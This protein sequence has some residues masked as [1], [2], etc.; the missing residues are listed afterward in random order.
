[1]KRLLSSIVLI[2][3]LLAGMIQPIFAAQE[4]TACEITVTETEAAEELTSEVQETAEAEI[5]QENPAGQTEDTDEAAEQTADVRTVQTYTT[6]KEGIAFIDEM[7]GGSC[8]GTNQL[9]S[10]EKTVNNFI[11]S[12]QLGLRQQQFDALVDLVMAY[13]SYIL[14]S[15]YKV[16]TLIASGNYTDRQ[17]AEA[18]CAWVKEGSSVSMVRLQRRL[19]E[20]KLFLYDSYDGATDRVTFRYVIFYPNG[21]TLEANSVLCYDLNEAY[22]SLPVATRSGKFFAG[23]YTMADG[24]THLCNSDKV[25]GNQTVYAHWSNEPVEQPNEPIEGDVTVPAVDMR[26]TEN[27][28]QFIKQYEGFCKYAIWDYGQYSIGYGTRCDPDDYPNGITEEEADYLLRKMLSDFEKVVERI[29]N[30]RGVKFTQSQF[31]AL[32]SFSFN[33]GEQWIGN[34]KIYQYVMGASYTES[35]F[36]NAM[37]SWASAGGSILT[38]LMRRRMDEANMYLNGRYEKGSTKYFGVQFKG[39]EG[40]VERRVNYYITGQPLGY[41]PAVT[42]EGYRLVGWF[43]KASGGTQYT[44]QTV[45]PSYGTLTLYARWE[46]APVDPPTPPTPPEPTDGF[47]DVPTDAWYYDYVMV[48]VESGLFGGVSETSFAP[49]QPMTRAMLVTVL[50]RLAGVPEVTAQIPFTDVAAGQWYEKAVRWAYETKIV[51][52]LSETEFGVN[53]N[54]TRE[55][56]TTMLYRYASYYGANVSARADLSAFR[57]AQTVSSYA[58]EPMQWAVAQEIVSGDGGRL[59]PTGNATRAQCAKMMVIFAQKISA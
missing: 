9:A 44:A 23:W 2:V 45:A 54:V 59:M 36:V 40:T 15:G 29:E 6:S 57:D 13:G 35:E 39:M 10:A 43:D 8:A 24:G 56:L 47:A 21:G 4:E 46:E 41:M 26:I 11:K 7:M 49:D 16:Q 37:G 33:L 55:Q 19:R 42:R 3:C 17:L 51:N 18:F 38:N 48:A 25:T 22:G 32:V 53:A 30:K 1:M 28:I 52:G 31:D 34:S 58:V 20:V 5:T 50:Y 14:T 12:N 27:C